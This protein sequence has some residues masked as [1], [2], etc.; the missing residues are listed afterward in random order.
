MSSGLHVTGIC[1]AETPMPTLNWIGKDA[2]IHHHKETSFRLLESDAR[3][4]LGHPPEGSLIVQ[5]GNFHGMKALL[6]KYAGAPQAA[7]AA[8]GGVERREECLRHDE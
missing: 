6:P 3:L 1:P 8:V 2:N 5:G 7:R 4:S